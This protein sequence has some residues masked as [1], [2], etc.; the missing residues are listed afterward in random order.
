MLSP[1]ESSGYFVGAEPYLLI[2]ET[3]RSQWQIP[4]RIV[5]LDDSAWFPSLP[6]LVK[7]SSWSRN[8][9]LTHGKT[10]QTGDW[11]V[12]GG[13]EDQKDWARTW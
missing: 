13:M 8:D 4:L 2:G 9:H 11:L 3:R 1:R 10:I 12:G 6:P 5:E 7:I